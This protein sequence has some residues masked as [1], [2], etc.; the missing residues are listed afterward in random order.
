MLEIFRAATPPRIISRWLLYIHQWF[1]N[2]SLETESLLHSWQ[3]YV[4]TVTKVRKKTG[5]ENILQSANK[6]LSFNK[7]KL[8]YTNKYILMKKSIN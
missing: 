5:V 4:I 3:S 2:Y 6:N 7:N 8:S 1:N